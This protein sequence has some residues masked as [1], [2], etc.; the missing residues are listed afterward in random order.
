M[1]REMLKRCNC[2]EETNKE[3]VEK[4]AGAVTTSATAHSKLFQPTFGGKKRKCKRCR[5]K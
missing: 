2:N 5:R 4:V 3:E 1:W